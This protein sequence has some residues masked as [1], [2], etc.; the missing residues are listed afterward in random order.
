M[1]PGASAGGSGFLVQYYVGHYHGPNLTITNFAE[2]ALVV[3]VAAIGVEILGRVVPRVRGA[4]RARRHRRRRFLAAAN[5][6]RRSRALMSELC[7]QGW[8]AQITLFGPGDAVP[9]EAPEGERARVALDW[10]ELEDDSGRVAIVRRVWAPTIAEALEA[11][12]ADRRT[13]ETLEQI[14]QGAVA[15]GAPWPDIYL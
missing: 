7:P 13:D 2:L 4:V 5:A 8:R 14:E 9:P 12:V 11:M 6:E 3:G 1:T 15:D 10:A